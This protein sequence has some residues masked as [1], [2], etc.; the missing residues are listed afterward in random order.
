MCYNFKILENVRSPIPTIKDPQPNKKTWNYLRNKKRP[1]FSQVINKPSTHNSLKDFT[2]KKREAYWVLVL[3]HRL[4][5]STFLSTGTTH[6]TFQKS[7]KQ[8]SVRKILK[9]GEIYWNPR[10]RLHRTTNHHRITI[11]HDL[12]HDS[13]S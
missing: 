1:H 12:L 13:G 9:R 10:S 2:K 7:G 3:N 11:G 6:K 8:D 5:S 4:L